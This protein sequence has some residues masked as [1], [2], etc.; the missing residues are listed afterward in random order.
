MR[1]V[2][3]MVLVLALVGSM[4]MPASTRANEGTGGAPAFFIGCCFGLRV[5]TQW[6]EGV[7][8]HW[9]EWASIIPGFNIWNGIECLNGLTGKEFA[10]MHG[11]N[12]Y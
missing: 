8:L 9:R 6:N 4:V 7:D 11:A 12:W 10:E 1:R 3:G 2:F 5:G